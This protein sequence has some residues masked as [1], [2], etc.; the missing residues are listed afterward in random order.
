MTWGHFLYIKYNVLMHICFSSDISTDITQVQWGGIFWMFL[1]WV[2]NYIPKWILLI[3]YLKNTA[4]PEINV[5]Q[6]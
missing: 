3:I 1:K 5:S 6:I 4:D 2:L